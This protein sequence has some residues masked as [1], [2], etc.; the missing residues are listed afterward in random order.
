ML[1]DIRF[2]S[3]TTV[4][5]LISTGLATQVKAS[6]NIVCALKSAKN[7]SKFVSVKFDLEQ[8]RGDDEYVS[9]KGLD[10]GGDNYSFDMRVTSDGVKHDVD[11]MFYENNHVQDEVGSSTW[12]VDL[13]KAKSQKPIISEPLTMKG[14]K[15]ADLACYF[16]RAAGTTTGIAKIVG[17]DEDGEE[18]V[19]S[20]DSKKIP[21]VN[22]NKKSYPSIKNFFEGTEYTDVCY[23]GDV[24]AAKE[25][26][27]ALVEA[28]NG[29]GDS[30]AEL[31]SITTNSRKSFVVTAKL[32]DESGEH[33]ESATFK[34]CSH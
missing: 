28:A 30:W 22:N 32:I 29:D 21:R 31:E 20:L 34:L 4:I 12:K 15:V 24:P 10:V 13:Q 23:E 27:S 7:P 33:T 9:S 14:K 6:E 3:L 1:R 2:S 17:S 19:V 5:A 8:E 18:F 11:I 16:N 25:L 26:L